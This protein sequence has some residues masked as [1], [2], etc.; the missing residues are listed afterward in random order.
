M[1]E[2][3]SSVPAVIDVTAAS[4]AW[5]ALPR[6]QRIAKTAALMALALGQ[7]RGRRR[8]QAGPV[9]VSI[10]LT[11]DAEIRRLNRRYRNQNKPTN[12]LSFSAEAPLLGDVVVAFGVTAA[13][14]RAAGKSMAAH[15]SHLVSHG[16]L[17]LLGYDHDS[18]RD[19]R[20]ME[21]LETAI[22]AR[23]GFPDPYAQ[24]PK[25]PSRRTRTA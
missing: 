24:P 3:S 7:K 19:A 18:D 23:L 25:P 21:K 11:S 17:H 14:A 6:A 8:K 22:M 20:V 10:L 13:E 15:L 12:V 9:E 1:T 5:R 16:V 2:S 4:A